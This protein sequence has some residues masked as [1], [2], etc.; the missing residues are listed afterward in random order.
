VLGTLEDI[1]TVNPEVWSQATRPAEIRYVDLSNVKW[2]RIDAITVLRASDAP[3]RAQRVLRPGDTIVGTVRPGNGSY[4]FISEEELTA[5]TGFA[6]LR[7]RRPPYAELVYLAA[8]AASNVDMLAHLA[9]GAAYPAVRPE[10]VAG[11]RLVRADDELL[12]RFSQVAGPFLGTI[13]GNVAHSR[14]LAAVR[15]ALL[16]RLMSGKLQIDN[17]ETFIER[18]T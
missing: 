10:V 9:D 14:T 16:P 3:S 6:V 13:A 8:T 18:T 15:E 11:T 2:G 12:Q 17:A 5:S 4:A 7:P 1:S